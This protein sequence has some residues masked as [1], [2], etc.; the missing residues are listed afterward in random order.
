MQSKTIE[1]LVLRPIVYL[2]IVFLT[3]YYLASYLDS[4]FNLPE[5]FSYPTNLIGLVLI[6]VGLIIDISSIST[7]ATAGKGT[8]FPWRPPKKMVITGPYR[9]TRNPIYL[10]FVFIMSGVGIFTN[11]L[12]MFLVMLIF[13]AAVDIFVVRW[14][15]KGL[16]ERFGKAYSEYKKKVPRW[17]PKFW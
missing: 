14:E 17:N 4:Y 7:F 11:L 2:F 8:P 15:E 1:L 16:E 13:I 10:A 9:Y 3:P 5:I 6:A 12:T